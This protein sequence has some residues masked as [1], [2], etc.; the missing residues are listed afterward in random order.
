MN[1]RLVPEVA[2]GSRKVTCLTMQ[3]V[4]EVLGLLRIPGR[5]QGLNLFHHQDLKWTWDFD[6]VPLTA[7]V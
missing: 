2:A 3:V 5:K 1:F 7:S 4:S 6:A